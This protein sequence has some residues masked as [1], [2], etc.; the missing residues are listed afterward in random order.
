MNILTIRS[1]DKGTIKVLQIST[2]TYKLSK[3]LSLK[4]LIL[5]PPSKLLSIIVDKIAFD[6]YLSLDKKLLETH[7]LL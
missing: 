5:L 2:N 3:N 7:F 1:L 6:L 4:S